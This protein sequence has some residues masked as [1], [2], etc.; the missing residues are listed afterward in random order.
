MWELLSLTFAVSG[1]GEAHDTTSIFS[2]FTTIQT[3][4]SYIS[5][6]THCRKL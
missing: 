1:K 6:L 2:P 4:K 3:V 5:A